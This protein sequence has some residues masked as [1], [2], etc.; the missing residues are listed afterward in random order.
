MRFSRQRA[1]ASETSVWTPL[2]LAVGGASMLWGAIGALRQLDAKLVLAWGTVSQLGLLV[3]LLS[4]GTGKAT[5]AAVALL[6]THAV[7]KAALFMV[8]GEI[9]IRAGTRQIRRTQRPGPLHARRGHRRWPSSQGASMAGVP[10]VLGFAAKEAV[11]EAT[12]KRR[13]HSTSGS[14]ALTVLIIAGSAL[15]VAY[16]TPAPPRAVRR[17]SDGRRSPIGQAAVGRCHGSGG[18]P[19]PC[20]PD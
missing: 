4:L 9:D 3:V 5:F 11:I 19:P 17:S 8:I 1:H 15:T 6:A 13:R 12:L 20:W 7:F 10:P 14:I 16:T 2:G 18:H